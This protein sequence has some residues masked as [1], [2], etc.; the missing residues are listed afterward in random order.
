MEL[1]QMNKYQRRL[2]GIKRARRILRVWRGI[3]LDI[4]EDELSFKGLIH[5]RQ[6]CSK[7]CCGNPRRLFGQFSRQEI[8]A[9]QENYNE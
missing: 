2:E 3:G 9:E 1:L 4:T 7:C 6:P 8:L 5:T